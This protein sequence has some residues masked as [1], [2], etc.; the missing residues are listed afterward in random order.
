MA[1][2]HRHHTATAEDYDPD[3][4]PRADVHPRFHVGTP[5]LFAIC[6][7]IGLIAGAGWG[8]ALII[9]VGGAIQG[10][11]FF[12]GIFSLNRIDGPAKR[13]AQAS[14]LPPA[15]D[16]EAGR[17]SAIQPRVLSNA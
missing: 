5:V 13:R 7:A 12:G 1:T 9:G 4:A 16:T 14:V 2:D 6:T 17:A 15:G 11:W 10:G 3:V 8:P